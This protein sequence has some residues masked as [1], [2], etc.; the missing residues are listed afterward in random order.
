MTHWLRARVP[1]RAVLNRCSDTK[2]AIIHVLVS[3]VT[4]RAP[5]STMVVL[6]VSDQR[7]FASDLVG[8]NDRDGHE[9]AFSEISDDA[10]TLVPSRR[11]YAAVACSGQQRFERTRA[12]TRRSSAFQHQRQFWK[13]LRILLGDGKECGACQAAASPCCHAFR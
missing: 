11:R 1:L 6:S 12:A 3:L 5:T 9:R 7:G 13:A 2:A 10:Q 8:L 4:A